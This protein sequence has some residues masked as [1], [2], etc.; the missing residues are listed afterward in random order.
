MESGRPVSDQLEGYIS[1]SGYEDGD[2]ADLLS[3]QRSFKEWRGEVKN[4]LMRPI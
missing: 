1:M 3:T 2:K 4:I